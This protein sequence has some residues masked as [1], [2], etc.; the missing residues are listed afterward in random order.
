[1]A[2][3]AN[4]A[5]IDVTFPQCRKKPYCLR[6]YSNLLSLLSNPDSHKFT[7]SHAPKSWLEMK[8]AERN[9]I[10]IKAEQFSIVSP[11]LRVPMKTLKDDSWKQAH[12]FTTVEETLYFY[13]QHEGVW[14]AVSVCATSLGLISA[15]DETTEKDG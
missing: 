2:T 11:Y 13:V 9:A 6:T 4:N 7:G 10:K 14:K 5:A 8:E 3:D 1:M 12:S 15:S